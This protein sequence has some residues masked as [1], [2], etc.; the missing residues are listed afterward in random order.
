VGFARLKSD[1]ADTASYMKSSV[2]RGTPAYMA[3]EYF[4]KGEC[5]TFTDV[6]ALGEPQSSAG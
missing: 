6:Y 5:G 4:Q 3:P 1:A 2:L